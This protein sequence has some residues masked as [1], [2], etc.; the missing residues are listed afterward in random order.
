MS[1]TKRDSAT[2]LAVERAEAKP[3]PSDNRSPG[4]SN[5]VCDASS[6]TRTRCGTPDA[7]RR[8]SGPGPKRACPDPPRPFPALAGPASRRPRATDGAV[9]SSDS[10]TTIEDAGSTRVSLFSP[11][12]VGGG[13]RLEP[14]PRTWRRRPQDGV[15]VSPSTSSC[16]STPVRIVWNPGAQ[17]GTSRG[18]PPP[19][20]CRPGRCPNPSSCWRGPRPGRKR[21]ATH[22]VELTS[23]PPGTRYLPVS[24][25]L[26]VIVTASS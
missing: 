2:G 6:T 17:S 13:S 26:S 18:P 12:P 25:K 4:P 7:G 21:Q 20:C 11:P 24:A 19:R 10:V 23:R 9:S 15:E 16:P 22:C 8:R 5:V 3:R 14:H 1:E